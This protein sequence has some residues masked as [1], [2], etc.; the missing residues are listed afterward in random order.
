MVGIVCYSQKKT[1]LQNNQTNAKE[2]NNENN[3][4]VRVQQ[5]ENI[6]TASSFD[7]LVVNSLYDS[8]VIFQRYQRTTI[9]WLIDTGVMDAITI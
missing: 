5:T 4:R 8:H 7:F 9:M 2:Q 1:C 6:L 3:L